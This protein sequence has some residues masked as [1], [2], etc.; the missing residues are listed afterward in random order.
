MV[1]FGQNMNVINVCR[2]LVTSDVVKNS[3][4]FVNKII[5]IFFFQTS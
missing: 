5:Q 1:K 3:M 2:V 4:C